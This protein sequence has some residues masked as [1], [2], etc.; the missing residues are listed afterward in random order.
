[1]PECA[2]DDCEA[3][4]AVRLHVPWAEN[5]EVCVAHAR[6]LVQRDGVVAEPLDAD[7]DSWL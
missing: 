2:E 5:R 7:G 4:A 6:A 1:M 3:P